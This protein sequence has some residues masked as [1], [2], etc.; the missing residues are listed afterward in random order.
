[1]IAG[2]TGGIGCGKS[3]VSSLFA[4]LGWL[5]LSA[6]AICHKIYKSRDAG[7]YSAIIDRWSEKVLLKNGLIDNKAIA[8]IVFNDIDELNW[9]NTQ[10]HP[11]IKARADDFIRKNIN[12]NIIF[13]IPL[14]FEAGWD[15]F[16]DI[17]IT[18]WA[19]QNIVLKR[20]ALRGLAPKAALARMNWQDNPDEKLSKAD[21]GLI[22]NDSVEN[23]FEQCK[24]IN[25]KIK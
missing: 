14:L 13:E 8:E 1:M 9:L 22:N 6:D 25:N 2:L 10:L 24:I 18:V 16:P 19:E 4:K 23:L 7:L 11:L 20:L 12:D 21:F 17:I 15:S 3:T 5:P